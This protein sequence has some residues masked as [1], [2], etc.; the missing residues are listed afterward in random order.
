MPEALITG[1]VLGPANQPVAF[2]IVRVRVKHF[3]FLI[4]PPTGEPVYPNYGFPIEVKTDSRGQYALRGLPAGLHYD[5]YEV[6]HPDFRMV[7]KGRRV[8]RSGEAN[9]LKLVAGCKVSGVVVDEAGR[10]LE[11]TEVQ[12]RQ[13]GRGGGSE[14]SSRTDVD[15]RFRFGNVEPG[16]WTVL[17]QPRRHAPANGTVV[18]AVDRAAENQYVVGPSAYISGRVI[19]ADGKPL[20]GA[21][22]GWAKPVDG[23]GEAN[24]DLAL[25]RITYTAKDGTFRF[26]PVA[27]GAYSLTAL[28]SEPRRIGQVTANANSPDVVIQVKLDERK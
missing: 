15:G 4:P 19:G 23:R 25:G 7:Q 21:A 1:Q 12:I 2:A 14:Q 3:Q 10:P 16:R 13:P 20:E 24:E 28:A 27:Q 6:I 8:L 26:G 11:G 17:I 18:A 22:V 5:W 9:D